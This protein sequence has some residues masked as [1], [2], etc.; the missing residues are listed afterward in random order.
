MYK[1]T[2]GVAHFE[3]NFGFFL[4]RLLLPAKHYCN[5]S[6]TIIS[7]NQEKSTKKTKRNEHIYIHTHRYLEIWNERQ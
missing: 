4:K 5:L 1:I 7:L 3:R 6:E 2:T